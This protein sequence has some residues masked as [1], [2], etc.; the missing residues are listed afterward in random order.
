MKYIPFQRFAQLLFDSPQQVRVGAEVLRAILQARSARWTEIAAAMAGSEAAA[1]K[2]LQRFMA[3]VDPRQV[4]QRLFVEKSAFVLGDPTE[5]ERLQARKTPYVGF[6]QGKRRG[7]WVLIL[8]T[9]FRGRA[10]PFSLITYSSR[11]IQQEVTS[12]N[13]YHF[14]AFAQVKELIG[15]RPLVLDREFSYLEL[16]QAL[17]VEGIHFVIRLNLGSHPPRFTTAAGEPVSLDIWPGQ[18][19]VRSGVLYQGQVPV[20]LIGVWKHTFREPL[21]VITDLEP[22]EALKIYGQRVKIEESFRDLKSLLGIERGMNRKQELM[23]KTLALV[24]LAYTVGM[25]TGEMLRDLLYGDGLPENPLEAFHPPARQ[26]KKWRLYSGLFL[27]LKKK[28]RLSR[29]AWHRVA[30]AAYALFYAIVLAPT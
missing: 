14:R 6:L 4:L 7:F 24:V 12:R 21:W 29:A 26:G 23:E 20:N 22:E 11:T 8:A 1:Y 25:L 15:P 13:R 3:Q 2:R 19:V 28:V 27:L 5:I 30:N 9:P 16:F 17:V 10:I 18:Q